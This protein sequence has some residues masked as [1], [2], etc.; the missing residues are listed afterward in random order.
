M[1]LILLF[2]LRL[3]IGSCGK[4]LSS[5]ISLYSF[6]EPAVTGDR[7]IHSRSTILAGGKILVKSQDTNMNA[8]TIYNLLSNLLEFIEMTVN[9]KT[10]K[11]N[12]FI[13]TPFL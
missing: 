10:T 8:R 1:L 3:K 2:S 13:D 12:C 4:V 11:R 7:H 5:S 6:V 9:M